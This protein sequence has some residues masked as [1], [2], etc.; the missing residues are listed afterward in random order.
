MA[1]VGVQLI[2]CG[3]EMWYT[4]AQFKGI[5]CTQSKISLL[6]N[7]SCP[8]SIKEASKTIC[9]SKSIQLGGQRWCGG[10][11]GQRFTEVQIKLLVITRKVNNTIYTLSTLFVVVDLSAASITEKATREKYIPSP[12]TW[13]ESRYLFENYRKWFI[14][15]ALASSG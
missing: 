4:I 2:Y 3:G 14:F 9:L 12:I 5:C 15:G 7:P 11:L 13:N 10:F 1:A 8:I 6:R